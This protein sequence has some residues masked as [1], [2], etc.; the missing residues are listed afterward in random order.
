[1]E[2]APLTLAHTH[3]RNAVLESRKS[4]PVAASEEHDLAAGEFATAAQSTRDREA[5]RMLHLLEQHHKKL[6]QILRFQHENPPSEPEASA[7]VG[8]TLQALPTESAVPKTDTQ[9]QP[10]KLSGAPHLIKR[11][12]SALATNL[13]S[14]R[15][16][17]AQP[18]RSSPVSPTLS[19]QQAGAKMTD[20]PAKIRTS[21]SRL[22]GTQISGQKGR[23]SRA[24]SQKQPWSPPTG[25]PTDITSQ[26]FVPAGAGE[27]TRHSYQHSTNDEPFQR[28]Y[29]TFEGLISKI[30]APLAFA[31]L[32]LGSDTNSATS[33]TRK[34]SA[35]TK[36]DRQTAVLNR[37]VS[38]AEPDISRIFSRAALKAV[39]ESTSG[40]GGMGTGNTAESFYV[41]PTTGGTVS[42][43]GI[44]TRGGKDTRRSSLDEGDDDFVDAKESPSS[45]ETLQSSKNKEK[46]KGKTSRGNDKLTS[47]QPAKTLEELQME[48]QALR[49]LSDTLSKR[50][51]MWE[52]NAQSSSMALQQSL[53][54][55]HHQSI[56]S[57]ENNPQPASAVPS[58][59]TGL[60]AA[61]AAPTEQDQRIKELEEIIQRSEKKLEQAGRENKKLH[62]MIGQYRDRWDRLKEN[63]KAR[64]AGSE[65]GAGGVGTMQQNTTE[66]DR[67][68]ATDQEKAPHEA[69][70]KADDS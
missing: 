3:A 65:A 63:A 45:P 60:S 44:L 59:T 34:S 67:T 54:A 22:R 10:P 46:G 43:A 6:A 37:A 53:K 41:V 56:Q 18:R 35:E 36:V 64:R 32:P 28:F 47:L 19:S 40:A 24:S 21:E 52:V 13:A 15:G 27:S 31:G 5:L 2:A 26:Q 68:G 62:T 29:S 48:N 25:S 20:G 42:Y 14:A 11:E 1:M 49:H 55:M 70:T 33:A 23:V 17:P 12:S 69:E 38:S 9:Q 7:T 58:P 4:N 61:P 39:R 16:I 8:L 66:A 50:L 57:P 30:S 51:H